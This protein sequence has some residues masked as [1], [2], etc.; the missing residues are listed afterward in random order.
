MVSTLCKQRIEYSCKGMT[1]DLH[2]CIRMFA[3]VFPLIE[4][5]CISVGNLKVLLLRNNGLSSTVGLEKLY[6]LE[7]L[8]ISHNVIGG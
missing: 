7:T 5:S 3:Y 1:V 2:Y 4:M 6:S 8:D